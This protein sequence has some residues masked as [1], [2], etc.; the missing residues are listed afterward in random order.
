LVADLTVSSCRW[1]KLLPYKI[2]YDLKIE[3]LI[4]EDQNPFGTRVSIGF[5]E[6]D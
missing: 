2:N 6:E 3:D 1:N 5:V 4:D